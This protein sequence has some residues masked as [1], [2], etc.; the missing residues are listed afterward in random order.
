MLSRSI[1]VRGLTATL[2]NMT[3]GG[4]IFAMPA[5]VAQM[6]GASAIY[7]YLACAIAM[8]CIVLA[9]SV[10]GSRVPSAG[11]TAVYAEA[12]FGPLAGFLTGT[13][14]WL[15]DTLAVAAVMAGLAAA[16]G[17]LVPALGGVVART[18]LVAAI[19][20][21]FAWINVRGVRH[22]TRV[23]EVMTIA[24]LLPLLIL[25]GAAAFA[26]GGAMWRVGPL[27]DI[28]TIGRA[29]LVLIF[30]FS[31][32]ESVM[33]LGGEVLRPTRTIP[34]ALVAALALVT[35]L[36]ISVQLA[37]AVGLGSALTATPNATLAIAA[38]NLLGP[39][40]RLL[41]A[42]GTVVSMTGFASVAV[43]TTPRLV[44][45]IA[46]RGLLP[47]WLARVHP[48]RRTPAAAIITH[49][50][51]SFLLSSSGTFAALAV[52]ASVS[53]VAV[54]FMACLSALQLQ[55]R[56]ITASVVSTS[57]APE[58]PVLHVPAPVLGA[59]AAFCVALLAQATSLELLMIAALLAAATV[60][61]LIHLVLGRISAAP[62]MAY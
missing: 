45:A 42:I 49:T 37:A 12:A 59:G 10:A 48:V 55:R 56:G 31:G 14:G 13:L 34:M 15:S 32:A 1:G 22:G 2:F 53:V 36:Y 20:G 3:V 44:Y 19:L 26:G 39:N 21:T 51:I 52:L 27:P 35:S 54:Y 8:L 33:A 6:V 30:A 47:S 7:A 4:G 46:C 25:V 24:K 17:A 9:F 40:G 41:L 29:S 5:L 28:A 60:W 16:I 38:G 50:T 62:E 23:A 57:S 11:G 18:V 43:M 58:R 61:Y